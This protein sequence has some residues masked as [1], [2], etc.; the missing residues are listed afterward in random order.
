MCAF[1]DDGFLDTRQS[2]EDDG[3]SA[4]SDIVHSSLSERKG[5]SNRDCPSRDSIQRSRHN[6]RQL[7][8]Y[9]EVVGCSMFVADA[10]SRASN[11][12]FMIIAQ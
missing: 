12:I 3:S 11:C 6:V 9:V 2:I 10:A 1:V 5:Y 7:D 4:T 8:V